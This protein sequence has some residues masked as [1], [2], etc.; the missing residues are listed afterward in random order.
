MRLIE[1]VDQAQQLITAIDTVL[2]VSDSTVVLGVDWE[3]LIKGRPLSLMQI[4]LL[5]DVYVPF[6]SPF[7]P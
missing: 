4:S 1:N 2:K 3:G 6:Y 5:D 7:N